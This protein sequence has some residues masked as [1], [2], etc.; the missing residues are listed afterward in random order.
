MSQIVLINKGTRGAVDIDLPG[1][2]RAHE[3][4]VHRKRKSEVGTG[5]EVVRQLV[6]VHR[7]RSV[8]L[9]K[10]DRLVVDDA[11]LNDPVTASRIRSGVLAV[12]PYRE[13]VVTKPKAKGV[14]PAKGEETHRKLEPKGR[15]AKADK[16]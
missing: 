6:K 7:P 5:D 11:I 12:Q 1:T 9:N 13:R 3:M 16:E 14:Q 2:G 4:L 15:I 8:T 10:G